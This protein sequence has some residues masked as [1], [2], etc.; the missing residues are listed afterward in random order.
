MAS[1]VDICNRALFKIG[2]KP[3]TALTDSNPRAVACNLWYEGVRDSLLREN[4]GNWNFALK[5]AELT[6]SETTPT[7]EWTYQYP[8]PTDCLRVVSLYESDENG[9]WEIEG[10]N[11]LTDWSTANI[12]YVA[13]ITDTTDFDPMFIDC[14][15]CRLA[16]EICLNLTDD[17]GKRQ[18]AQQEYAYWLRK[19]KAADGAG[20]TSSPVDSNNYWSERQ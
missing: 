14:L 12:K 17:E 8:L 9:D 1:V 20:E 16:S 13:Q 5:R 10:G 19:A 15:V 3:I 6:V 18:A 7:F 2:E 4:P 11:L